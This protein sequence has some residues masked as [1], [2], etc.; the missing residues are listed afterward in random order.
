MAYMMDVKPPNFDKS[1][2]NLTVIV[3]RQLVKWKKSLLSL[4]RNLC[5]SVSNIK[6]EMN[7]MTNQLL[8]YG[9]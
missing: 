8:I 1:N 7:G 3:S 9:Q 5:F 4:S 6:R 2:S